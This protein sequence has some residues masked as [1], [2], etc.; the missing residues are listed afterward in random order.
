MGSVWISSPAAA[1]RHGAYAYQR[2]APGTVKAVGTSVAAVVGQFPWG[3]DH[4][5]VTPADTKT[6]LQTF[7][8]AGMSRV[9]SGYLAC[10]GKAFPTLKVVRVTASSGAVAAH[11]HCVESA[12]Q[13]C[14]ITLNSV[15]TAGNDVKWT[16]SNAS[17]GNADHF[18]LDVYVTGATG[19]TTDSFRNVNLHTAP[20]T[21]VDCTG[22]ILVASVVKDA[23]GRPDN[24]SA[25]SF[26]EGA[27]GSV[28]A[29]DYVGTAGSGDKGLAVL[30]GDSSVRHVF[31]DHAFTA[32][33]TA[34]VNA[35]LKAHAIL[36]GDRLAY[37]AADASQTLGQVKTLANGFAEERV[38]MTD[39]WVY[40][41]D[42]TTGAEHK[43]PA[44]SFAASVA[45]QTSP[46]TSIAWKAS[47]V[48]TMLSGIVRLE[49][50]R[51]NGAADNTDA[52]VVTVIEEEN[53]GFRFEAGVNTL[54]PTDPSKKNIT[55]TRM[56]DYIAVSYISSIRGFV[57]APNVAET[58]ALETGMLQKFMDGLKRNVKSDPDHTPFVVDYA[59]G[60]LSADNSEQDVDSGKF[61]IPL[62]VKIGASQEQIFLAVTHGEG[63]SFTKAV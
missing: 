8:P 37:V 38:V 17:D 15:G 45:C 9:G 28:A 34:T 52:G 11:A 31:D 44:N 48:G 47:E 32:T 33:G 18:N 4:Q 60:N 19:T 56:G 27:D 41:K 39:P 35:G 36:M 43:V 12:T 14:T 63:V 26:S 21:T 57:D 50:N 51:G 3:P 1:R 25:Q 7:A 53:G 24:A 30:E 29:A 22:K 54:A 2:V 23:D 59:I 49:T 5:V 62:S 40:I 20:Y 6:F 55:R 16:V 46:S 42:D 10:L 61:T 58:W 13:V